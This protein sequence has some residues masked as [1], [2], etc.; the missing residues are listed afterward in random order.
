MTNKNIS[1]LTAA[2]TPLVGTELVPVWD[3]ATKKVTVTNLTS[4]RAVDAANLTATTGPLIAKGG[5]AALAASM[6][7]VDQPLAGLSRIGAVG[8]GSSDD[9]VA[10]NLATRASTAYGSYP[11]LDLDLHGGNY[12]ILGNA[13]VRKGQRVSG[14][15]AHLYMGSTGSI[16][17]GM[18]S[19]GVT[20]P[21]GH[22]VDIAGIWFEGGNRPIDCQISGYTITNCFFSYSS[23][24]PIFGG[25]DG[26]MSDIIFDDG[27][28]LL[29]LTG[30]NHS[31]TNCNFYLGN[32][33]IDTTELQN[34]VI[35]NC[36]FNYARVNTLAWT[37]GE[38]RSV[39]FSN[40]NFD[41][42]EQHA[43]FSGFIF[44]SGGTVSGDL[45]F[46]DCTYRNQKGPAF[47]LPV[48]T[49]SCEINLENCIF[50]G[51]KTRGVHAQSTTAFGFDLAG[52][53]SKCKLS[54]DECKFKNLLDTPI[55]VSTNESLDLAVQNSSF[56]NCTG[57]ESISIA[58]TNTASVFSFGN[59]VGD[60]KNLFSSASSGS[61][62]IN[63]WL[64][65]WLTLVTSGASVYVEIPYSGASLFS[66][67]LIGNQNPGSNPSYRGVKSQIVSVAFDYQTATG[68]NTQV[69]SA[70]LLTGLSTYLGFN[71]AITSE[72]NTLGGGVQAAGILAPGKLIISCPSTYASVAFDVQYLLTQ[73]I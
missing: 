73:N 14:N 12:A 36:T 41:L 19:S 43:G 65:K 55:K 40:C 9:T 15:G 42:N 31:L 53:S 3:G 26:I 6:V 67:N 58:A 64:K 50:D 45:T 24:G 21:S 28:S 69:T 47:N 13:Y 29:L 57:T 25:T 62:V 70:T 10:W 17:C 38:I 72:I 27:S 61:L 1:G 46:S 49:S 32:Y 71:L 2:T 23:A 18:N 48:A 56:K 33:H 37:S 7:F 8:D 54:I 16:K 63:G 22:P 35:S 51:L 68:Q 4:G 59:I 44:V 20:D 66:V 34:S 39:R 52:G 11:E 5:L 30:A 60:N